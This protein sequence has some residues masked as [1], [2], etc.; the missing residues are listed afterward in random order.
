[1]V[2]EGKLFGNCRMHTKCES[3]SV[4]SMVDRMYVSPLLPTQRIP[5]PGNTRTNSSN[6]LLKCL[7]HY[8][9]KEIRA[10]WVPAGKHIV[11]ETN[12]PSQTAE[13]LLINTVGGA[14][15]LQGNMDWGL[16]MGMPHQ[17]REPT[18]QICGKEPVTNKSTGIFHHFQ[19]LLYLLLS[20]I[21]HCSY[22]WLGL[23]NFLEPRT[24]MSFLKHPHTTW[25]I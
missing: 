9:G 23:K 4:P 10:L 3:S 22:A 2:P 19:S 7:Q 15:F 21:I 13:E 18:S 1:M 8:R 17:T 5:H 24:Q 25:A 14:P 20:H 16:L 11:N 6:I 12:E